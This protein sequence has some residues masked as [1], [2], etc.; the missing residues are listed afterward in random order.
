M[1]FDENNEILKDFLIEAGEILEL[2]QEQL[3]ELEKTPSDKELINAIFRGFH[4]IKGGAGFLDLQPMVDVCH[5]AESIFD[6]IRN[7]SMTITEELMDVILKAV[8]RISNMYAETESGKKQSAAPKALIKELMKWVDEGNKQTLAPKP[9]DKNISSDHSNKDAEQESSGISDEEFEA[10]LDGIHG[11]GKF[12]ILNNTDTSEIKKTESNTKITAEEIP[13]THSSKEE[14]S[15]KNQSHASTSL[16]VEISKLDKMMNIVGE[17]VL[18]RNRLLSLSGAINNEAILQSLTNL[19][20]VT[21]DLQDV[22]MN[23]RMQPIKKIFGRFPRLVRDL[24]RN[25]GK[26]INLVLQGEETDLDKNLVD[27]LADPLVHLIRNAIDHGIEFPNEREKESKSR[28]GTIVLSASQQGDHILLRIEDDGKGIDPID[29]KAQ[30]MI[31]GV[32]DENSAKRMSDSEVF[33]LIFA[34][35]F[36]TKKNVSDISGRGVG[37]D[38]VKNRITKLNG[39]V[40][41]YSELGVGTVIE[42]KVP[43]TLAILPT[44]M[45]KVSNKIFAIPLSSVT[46]IFKWNE[47]KSNIVDGQLTLNI[48]KKNIPIFH[49]GECFSLNNEIKESKNF[50]HVVMLNKNGTALGVVVDDLLGQEEVVIKPLSKIIRHTRGISGATIISDGGIALIVDIAGLLNFYEKK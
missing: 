26:E 36:T 31:C 4:T 41:V 16:R 15:D 40:D 27:A 2:L 30:A 47:E 49:L 19:D 20:L 46:E 1:S 13:S 35:G 21:S 28:A 10:L 33:N 37:M 14:S 6:L 8:D 43:L 48:R 39:A 34:P 9:A 3:I 11:K 38:V 18:V 23:T 5:H 7:D 45:V 44:L 17:L 12:S 22:V 29:I 25:L 50:S 32:I 24:S 42:L